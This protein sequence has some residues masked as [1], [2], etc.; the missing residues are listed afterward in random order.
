MKLMKPKK[1]EN[2]NVKELRREISPTCQE[3]MM[4]VMKEA[5]V[6]KEPHGSMQ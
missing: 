3:E 1:A 6:G 5:D 2:A 4:K